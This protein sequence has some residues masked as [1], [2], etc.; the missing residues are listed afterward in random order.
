[1]YRSIVTIQLQQERFERLKNEISEQIKLGYETLDSCFLPHC[2]KS[3]R[4]KRVISELRALH[5]IVD[6]FCSD[7]DS[8]PKQILSIIDS[9]IKDFEHEYE[10]IQEKRCF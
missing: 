7:L 3:V 2:V 5:I 1:M 6:R 10:I 4:I 9:C 8:E